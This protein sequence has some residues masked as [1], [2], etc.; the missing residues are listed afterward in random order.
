M[1][2]LLR[3]KKTR[4][5]PEVLLVSDDKNLFLRLRDYLKRW[6]RANLRIC[7]NQEKIGS[8]LSSETYKLKIVDMASGCRKS[9]AQSLDQVDQSQQTNRLLVVE[10]A[11]ERHKTGV[12]EQRSVAGV[13]KKS[14]SAFPGETERELKKKIKEVL[15][16]RT[17]MYKPV[18]FD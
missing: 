6:N 11:D 16:A 4:R 18:T 12:G 17:G 2:S 15:A 13:W 9:I 8:E 3:E 1:K 7:T 10:S 14:D 5:V